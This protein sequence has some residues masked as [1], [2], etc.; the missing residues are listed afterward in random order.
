[1]SLVK[2]LKDITNQRLN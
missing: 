2:K 1:T